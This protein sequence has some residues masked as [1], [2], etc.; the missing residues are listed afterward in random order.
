MPLAL[1]NAINN[2][3]KKNFYD[4]T[5]VMTGLKSIPSQ[6]TNNIL[7]QLLRLDLVFATALC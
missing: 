6:V 5:T 1:G 7:K 3:H 2:L 4:I